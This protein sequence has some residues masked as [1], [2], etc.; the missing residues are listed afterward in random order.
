M[1]TPS[2]CATPDETIC[3]GPPPSAQ[4][5]LDIP[6]IISAAEVANVD[7]IHPGYGFLSEKAEF[8]EI[9]RSCKINFIGPTAETIAMVG[10]K[11]RA[12]ELA[13][14]CD[15]PV[16]PGSEGIVESEDEAVRVAAEIGYPV[17]IKGVGGRWRTRHARRPKRARA[18]P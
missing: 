7:A 11:A 18:S 10:D 8:A 2:T 9:C 16:V 12:K 5:Y 1:K 17:I 13:R 3:I 14:S 4:S 15:V 6:R